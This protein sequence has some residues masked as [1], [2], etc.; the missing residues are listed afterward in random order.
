M[1]AGLRLLVGALGIGFA[2]AATAADDEAPAGNF[3]LEGT[4][5]VL[6]HY[7]DANTANP[8][9]WRWEDRVWIFDRTGEPGRGLRWVEYPIVVFS[10]KEGRFETRDK[11]SGSRVL[12][13]WEPNP[14]QRAE[15][16]RGLAVNSRGRAVKTL[17]G[18]D[19]EGWRTDF[20]LRS[21]GSATLGYVENWSVEGLPDRPVFTQT[22]VLGSESD[23]TLEGV[24]R[25]TTE[26][27]EPAGQDGVELRGR[28]ERDGTRT[29]RFRLIPA[30]DIGK[31]PD[32]SKKE[33]RRRRDR[34][35]GWAEDG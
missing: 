7:R 1:A 9:L 26:A 11:Q 34:L 21:T 19:A 14:G 3:D 24:T 23:Q 4:W 31:V 20:R 32:R 28:F 12:H 10:D 6:V 30:G 35:R 5:F 17:D 18:S 22:D 13:A 2:A 25:Y 15:I 29:G 8:E 16:R 27:L 33:K